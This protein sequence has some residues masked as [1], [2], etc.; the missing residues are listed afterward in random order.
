ME[1]NSGEMFLSIHMLVFAIG[2]DS[3]LRGQNGQHAMSLT[4]APNKWVAC[5][6]LSVAW[7]VSKEELLFCNII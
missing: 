6:R 1:Q 7:F 2:G 4:L 5:L 3:S